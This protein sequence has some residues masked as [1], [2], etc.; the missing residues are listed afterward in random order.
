MSI[1]VE[2]NVPA[3]VMESSWMNATLS[4]HHSRGMKVAVNIAVHPKIPKDVIAEGAFAVASYLY[5]ELKQVAH[6]GEIRLQVGPDD[7]GE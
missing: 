7:Q 1:E 5:Q 3:S 6:I 2:L 4:S